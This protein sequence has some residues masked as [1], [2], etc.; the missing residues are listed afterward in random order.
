MLPC[1]SW[2]AIAGRNTKSQQSWVRAADT[3][4]EDVPSHTC[5]VKSTSS[6]WESSLKLNEMAQGEVIKDLH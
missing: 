5:L 2:K 4:T 3:H 1:S 6:P